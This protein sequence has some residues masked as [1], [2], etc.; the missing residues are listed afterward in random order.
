[1]DHT[2]D[3]IFSSDFIILDGLR[4]GDP[5]DMEIVLLTSGINVSAI[6][7]AIARRGTADSSESRW[8]VTACHA[9]GRN[10]LELFLASAT[11]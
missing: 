2:T 8:P 11:K 7:A 6:T 5:Y 9:G 4:F 3:S 10:M 1:M